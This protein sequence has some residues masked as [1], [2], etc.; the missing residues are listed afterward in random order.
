MELNQ[1]IRSIPDFPSAG[2]M[3]CD[4]SPLLAHPKAFAFCIERFA[5]V[6]SKME[7]EAIV[8]I[9]SRGFLFAAP[10]AK[11]L[12]LPLALV[13]KPGK[14]PGEKLSI[15]YSLEYGSGKLEIHSDAI[16]DGARVALID[17]V[18]AT[19]GTASAAQK[20]ISMVGGKLVVSVFLIELLSL[21]GRKQLGEGHS[22]SSL[23][24]F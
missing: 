1:Y 6:V 8:A 9:E 13:R 15:D 19:G 10:V 22:V 7:C 3:F 21:Q 18:L 17:D 4:I 20:L 11:E 12:K 2:V 24:E 23:I 5:E 16:A 14:L